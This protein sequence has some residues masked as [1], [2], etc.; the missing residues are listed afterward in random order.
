MFAVESWQNKR[1]EGAVARYNSISRIGDI[2]GLVMNAIITLHFKVNWLFYI[3]SA[4]CLIAF[5]LLW[6]LAS[7]PRL[8]LERHAFP[9]RSF[10]DAKET[11]SS[12][13][14]VQF[15]DI[16]RFRI[17]KINLFNLKPLQLFFLACFVHWVGINCFVV[18]ETPLLKELGMSDSFILAINAINSF[19]MVLAFGKVIP[20]LRQSRN[21][22]IRTA[23][24]WRGAFIFGWA[25][26][27][28]LL[29]YPSPYVF[30]FPILLRILWPLG[31]AMI[32]LSI[33]TYAIS[34]APATQKGATQGALSSTIA[35]ASA[36]GSILGG[37]MIS[38]FGF[39][40]GFVLAA[41]IF[42]LAIPLF[43]LRSQIYV[44]S[45]IPLL[46][47]FGTLLQ[48]K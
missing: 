43:L 35:V 4:L 24:F 37:F 10:Q 9:F 23:I 30:L 41:I 16:R 14:I 32:W 15:L 17:P 39:T 11:L 3:S 47:L 27:S 34:A 6:R 45:K 29:V 5:I 21:R 18:G 13:T 12:K 19:V 25:G 31:F 7:E 36:L 40:V 38:T 42:L 20:S 44:N 26:I 33:S 8:T 1:W 2:L 48:D 28:L 46:L 22:L